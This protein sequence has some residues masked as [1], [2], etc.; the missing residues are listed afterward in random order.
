MPLLIR[1]YITYC[2][3]VAVLAKPVARDLVAA[4]ALGLAEHAASGISTF[5]SYN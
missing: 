5:S 2:A 1:R 4:L 3:I